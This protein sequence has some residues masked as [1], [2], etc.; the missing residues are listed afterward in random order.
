MCFQV[1]QPAFTAPSPRTHDTSQSIYHMNEI[2]EFASKLDQVRHE[3]FTQ[4][5]LVWIGWRLA[6]FC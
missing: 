3:S 1:I 2:G 6:K 5:D 4:H